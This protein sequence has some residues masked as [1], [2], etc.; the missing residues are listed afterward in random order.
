MSM[1]STSLSQHR[2]LPRR[3]ARSGSVR[4]VAAIAEGTTV[5]VNTSIKVLYMQWVACDVHDFNP[6][7]KFA[8][9]Q[10]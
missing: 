10:A 5:R 1:I 4:V 8:F 7:L 9:C 6:F 3:T 2:C